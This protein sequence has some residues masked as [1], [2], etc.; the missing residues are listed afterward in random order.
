VCVALQILYNL[1]RHE[2]CLS[3]IYTAGE[4]VLDILVDQVQHFRENESVLLCVIDIMQAISRH[5]AGIRSVNFDGEDIMRRLDGVVHVLT[6]QKKAAAAAAAKKLARTALDKEKFGN[7]RVE[8]P[9]AAATKP[10]A[11]KLDVRS[12]LEELA[13]LQQS[14]AQIIA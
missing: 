9:R 4:G 2:Q 11:K 6:R 3:A 12:G 8:T 1:S 13:K 10:T 7:I 5:P 14:F